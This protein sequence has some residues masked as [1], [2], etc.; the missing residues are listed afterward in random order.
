V[1]S[2][3]LNSAIL[4]ILVVVVSSN[5]YLESPLL[6]ELRTS[7]Y[8][9]LSIGMGWHGSLACILIDKFC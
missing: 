2:F 9:L 6:Q 5:S 8:G 1:L 7:C 4:A 3:D